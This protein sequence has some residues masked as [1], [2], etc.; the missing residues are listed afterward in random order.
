MISKKVDIERLEESRRGHA[1][2]YSTRFF[3]ETVPKYEILEEG[4][5][6]NAAYQLVHDELNLDGNP[7][8]NL[9]SFV[10]TWMEPEAERLIIENIGRNFIDHF[11]YPQ[12]EVIHERVVNMLARLFNAP[13]DTTF[14]GTATVGSS[15]AVTLGLLAHK[16]A[17][18]KRREAKGKPCGKPN[19]VYG[20]D[21]HVCWDKFAKY[22]DIEPRIIPMEPDRF[23]ITAVGVEERIDENTICVG[24]ILGTTFTGEADPIAEISALL[25]G[26]YK[27]KDWDIPVHVDAA[28]G[29]FVTPFAN[30]ELQ[31]DFR[32]PRVKSINVSG[33]KYGLVYPGLGWLI[34]R[35][36]SDLPEDLV[37]YVNYLGDEMPTYTLNFSRGS[38]MILAQYYNLLRL[39]RKGYARIATNVLENARYVAEQLAD[40]G[41]F[42]VLN[43]ADLLPIVTVKLKEDAKY[44]VFDLSHKL[45]ERGWIVPAYTL[46]PNAEDIAIMRVVVKE[47]F[48]R[49]LADIF[50]AD[51]ANVCEVLEGAKGEVV[52]PRRSARRGHHVN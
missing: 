22:F 9:A 7:A 27:K 15:E 10:T 16:W 43:T 45:R 12:T 23:A 1:S 42:E 44:T 17:W 31:W 40:S 18:K 8:L 34:F 37:F 33:H 2:T 4:M 19:I 51:V 49:D 13:E 24:A 52:V 25:D 26:V 41:R 39:G 48:G 5:P 50:V 35:D 36:A 3:D 21:A 20:A 6:A 46:P 38:A 30:P 47:N 28:S 11:E 29:G 14:A 32:L